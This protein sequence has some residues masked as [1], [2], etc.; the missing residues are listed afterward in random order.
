MNRVSHSY[1]RMKLPADGRYVVHLG[2]VARQGGAEYGYRLRLSAPRPDFELRVVPSSLSLSSKSNGLLSVYALRKD[3]FAG[4]IELSLQASTSGFSASPATLT[5]TQS[6]VQLQVSTER[7]STPEPCTLTVVGRG[8]V[9]SQEVTR[10]AVPAEDRMQAFLWRQLVPATDLKVLVYDPNFQPP[11]RR[12]VQVR[13]KPVVVTMAAPATNGISGTNT[14]SAEQLNLARMQA[15]GRLK[16][17]RLLFDE[18]MLTD[19]FYVEKVA[20]CERAL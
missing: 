7:M 17:L 2:D 10:P 4:P 8:R 13:P 6:V 5:V 15:V 20:E 1:F 3:G 16:V 11:P 18:E 12:T 9:G 19:E 14:L